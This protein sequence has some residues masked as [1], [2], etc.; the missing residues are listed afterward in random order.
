M[1]RHTASFLLNAKF[2]ANVMRFQVTTNVSGKSLESGL[3][4]TCLENL[5]VSSQC[6][7]EGI[8]VLK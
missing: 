1:L 8:F 6:E 7:S 2:K 5:R 3:S 4:V